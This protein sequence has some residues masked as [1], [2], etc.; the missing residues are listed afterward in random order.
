LSDV[1]QCNVFRLV[2]TLGNSSDLKTMEIRQVRYFMEVAAAGSF[3][4]AAARLHL[5]QPAV[6][7][8]IKALEEELGVVLLAR[9]KRSVALT[10][11]GEIF[12]EEAQDLLAHIDR[13]VRRVQSN[14]S[15]E[16]LRVGY[17]PSLASDLLPKAIAH[18]KV[19]QRNVRVDLVDMTPKEICE[20]AAKGLID[21]AI[22][23]RGV[24]SRLRGVELIE[25]TR[26]NPVLVVPKGHRLARLSKIPPSIL[27]NV[28]LYGLGR[29][30]FPE[31]APR[32]RAILKPYGVVP[33]LVSQ[34]S[35]GVASL[36]AK[37][38]ADNGASVLTEG[39]VDSL[40]ASL[41]ARPFRPALP[42]LVI[43]AALF[44]SR[45]SLNA[46]G[47]AR[48][49]KEEAER[50]KKPGLTKPDVTHR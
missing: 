37:M 22:I 24:E 1:F 28:H 5:T 21:V 50:C 34:T 11:E 4:Q 33:A 35:D 30:D 46:E 40:P 49:L 48:Q 16:V 6:S 39:V 18:F 7:R 25:I 9:G 2:H 27:Q 14:Q 13:V 15:R 41:V 23:P 26:L 17:A 32:L 20:R 10:Q 47:F 12:Y 43:L 19:L 42:P 3:N 36:F 8:Q 38:I 29:R 44:V 31:Y 45:P